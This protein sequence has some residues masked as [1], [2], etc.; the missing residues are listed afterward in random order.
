VADRLK[1]FNS[2]NCTRT[3]IFA[4]ETPIATRATAPI[5]F[6]TLSVS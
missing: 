3:G 6:K 2:A 4:P 5:S 1:I